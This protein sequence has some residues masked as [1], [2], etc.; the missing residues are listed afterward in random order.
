MIL[1]YITCI[2]MKQQLVQIALENM[3]QNRTSIV[4]ARYLP[5]KSRFNCQTV[6]S[7]EKL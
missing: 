7:K 1:D 3:M 4:I 6:L 2:E 5:F